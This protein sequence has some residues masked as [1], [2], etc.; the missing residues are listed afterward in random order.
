MQIDQ[1][2]RRFKSA[3]SRK[4]VNWKS[5]YR[6]AMELFCPHREAFYYNVR[7]Q[8]K[9]QNL[10]TSAPYVA[11]DKASNNIH[12][13]L[14]PPQKKWIE[15]RPGRMVP[16]EQKQEAT[17]EL[18]DITNT[19]F[20]YVNMSNFDLAASEF[21][22][23]LMIGTAAILV[24]GT[25][26]HPLIFTAVPLNELYIEAGPMGSVDTVFRKFNI[27][28]RNIERTW[29][30]V[31]IDGD[32][33]RMIKES[34]DKEVC[35]IEGTF[36]KKI[37]QFDPEAELEIEIDGYGYYVC[38]ER[39]G[40]YIVERDMPVSPW[41]VARWSV[42]SGEIWGRGPC[43]VALNDAKTLNQFVKLHMQGL[44]LTVHPMYTVVDD[45][46]ININNIRIGP[47][48]MIPV[49][50]NDGVFG[51]SISRLADGGGNMQASQI[52]LAR[53]EQSINDQ[54]YTEPLGPVNL[55]VKTA[56]EISIRQ[57]ELAKRIGSAF[58][59]IQYEFI[60]PLVNAI[61]YRLDQVG[62]INMNNFKADGQIINIEAVSPLA[63]SQQQDDLNNVLK[64]VEFA[65]GTY[66][67]EL[68][69]VLVKPDQTIKFISEQ[70]NIPVDLLP[71]T[72]EMQQIVQLI[73]QITGGQQNAGQQPQQ[74]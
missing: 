9:G 37:M 32:L 45:G 5:Y 15:L 36:P 8:K 28:Y 48:A 70:L 7:G 23:D 20:D 29:D 67:P 51:P 61:L 42:L 11:L 64:L 54:M 33:A 59:R 12:S 35:V 41:V 50:A 43:I 24:Q 34:P 39:G 25:R 27:E 47:G 21:Y 26:E 49:S 46:L 6:D 73:S 4:E 18:Q 72:E 1:F 10:Y 19:V 2:K 38:L 66:G 3:M 30:D 16:E 40:S 55:P 62:I 58:G 22:K 56:T 60:K 69:M 17:K 65:A 44:E 13:S 74:V 57:Q 52:E 14:T 68:A 63:Q 31:V 53:L 71:T